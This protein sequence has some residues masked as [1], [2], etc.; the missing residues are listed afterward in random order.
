MVCANASLTAG[1][2]RDV[3][4]FFFSNAIGPAISLY[5]VAVTGDA[6][7]SRRTPI[8]ILVYGGLGIAIGLWC[9]GKK[10]IETI[11]EDLTKITPSRY[12]CVKLA[13]AVVRLREPYNRVANA[14]FVAILSVA[15]VLNWEPR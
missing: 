8:W 7:S 11:G 15:C 12:V 1:A 13:L 14:S 2:Q 6:D 10:V 5:I 9:W 3:F 4:V